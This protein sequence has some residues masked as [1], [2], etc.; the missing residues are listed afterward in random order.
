MST[1][2]TLYGLGVRVNVPLAGLAGLS[3]A[4]RIDVDIT[5]GELP[6]EIAAIPE[7]HWRT[8]YISPDLDA[9]G[10]PS[11]SGAQDLDG[12]FHS[13]RYADGTR[14]VVNREA[15]RIWA[16]WPLTSTVEDTATYLLGPALGFVL[17]RRGIACLHASAI[18]IDGQ[19]IALVGT[20][21]AGKS[22]A[23]ATFAQMGYPI[24]SDD[25]VAID[26][27]GSRFFVQPAYPRVRLWPESVESLFGHEDALQRLTPS[28]TKRFLDLN[29]PEYRFQHRAL[30]LAAIYLL[31]ARVASA[32]PARIEAVDT[33]PSLMFLVS[34]TSTTW[35]LD[36]ASRAREFEVLSRIAQSV[37]IR[38]T[39]ASDS[40]SSVGEFC[41][42][43]VD[44]F[45][46]MERP[47]ARTRRAS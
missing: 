26:D 41:R 35:L 7:T 3:P 36:R 8:Y 24:L 40:L 44:D 30:P 22:T 1:T 13:I 25:V 14:I 32:A 15:T 5:L 17:R 27:S 28:W 47:A 20:S 12:A 21:G 11:L 19:A 42:S 9:Q 34:D 33:G 16:T 46:A 23:A 29:G 10:R 4:D 37:P 2:C 39:N 38:R 45:R 18:A 43:L 6:G 31:G